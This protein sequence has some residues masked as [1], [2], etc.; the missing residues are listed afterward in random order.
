V[1]SSTRREEKKMKSRI[2][3]MVH[4]PERKKTEE[5]KNYYFH[6]TL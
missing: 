1:Q 6:G 4:E 2:D 3:K 5:R